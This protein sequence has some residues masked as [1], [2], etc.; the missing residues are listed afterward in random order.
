MI[1]QYGD[2]LGKHSHSM[3]ARRGLLVLGGKGLVSAAFKGGRNSFGWFQGGKDWF[4]LVS[5]GKDQFWVV[6]AHSTF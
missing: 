5:C 2:H 6:L 4:R 3:T 1:L